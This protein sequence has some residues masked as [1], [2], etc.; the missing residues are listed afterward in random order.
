[1]NKTLTTLAA[2]GG[3]LAL[4]RGLRARRRIPFRGRTAVISGGSRGLGLVLA[5]RLADEGANL[6]L[7]ARTAADLDRARGELE[8]RGAAVLALPCDVREREQVE[9]AVAKAA[10][11]FGRIDVLL[12]DAGVIQVGPQEHMTEADYR[13]AMGV[14]FWGAYYL[15]EA[16]LPHLPTDG[17]GRVG[18]VASIG[19]RIAVPHLA[20]YSASKF[21]LVGYADAMRAELSRRGIRVTTVTPGL[22]RT[23]SHPN[24]LFKGDHEKEYA[25]FSISDANPLLSASAQHAAQQ[26]LDAVRHGDPAL[27]IT[28]PAKLGAALD[29]LFPG[30]TGTVMK[31]AEHLLPAPAG[32]S[33]DR[34]QTGWESFSAASP[35]VLTR[36]AD[37]AVAENNELRGHAPPVPT[38]GEAG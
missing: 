23:G 3:G 6:V 21:A 24:A 19:G 27:T 25:W 12:H 35:S 22:M 10:E 13:E 17:T 4:W 29:G 20:P 33:G 8:G 16:V 18:Y 31:L 5:R 15:T 38:N 32:W 1:M 28:I 2:A 11:R 26:I 14:H 36:P 30:L 37:E 34:R 9:R 7:L